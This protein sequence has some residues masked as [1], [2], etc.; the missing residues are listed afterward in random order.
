[1]AAWLDRSAADCKRACLCGNDAWKA[2]S[3]A[4]FQR[5]WA[6]RHD[7]RVGCQIICQ[8]LG[9]RPHDLPGEVI[10]SC[11]HSNINTVPVALV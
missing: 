3:G 9:G 5:A 2:Q 11:M 7:M 10:V 8:E 1:M 6:A 4:K